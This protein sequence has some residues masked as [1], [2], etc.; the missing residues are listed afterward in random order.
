VK[1]KISWILK[2]ACSTNILVLIGEQHQDIGAIHVES[3]CQHR[4]AYLVKQGQ[5]NLL[6]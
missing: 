1:F 2:N 4:H 3:K 5:F 6:E